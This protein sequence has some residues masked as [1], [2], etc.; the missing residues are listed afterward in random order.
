MART[1]FRPVFSAVALGGVA[2]LAVLA[3][4]PANADTTLSGPLNL[5]TATSFSVLGAS[6]VTNISTLTDPQT[7]SLDTDL[8]LSPGPTSAITGFPPGIVLG[9]VHAT[10]AVAAQ[11]QT[12]L[13]TAYNTAASLTPQTTGLTDLVGLT[14]SPGVYSGG[15]LSLSGDLTLAGSAESVWVFQASSTLITG[16]SSHIILTGGASVC[17]V[18]WQV[19]TSATLGTNSDFVG[20]I[21]AQTSIT[22]TTGADIEGRLLARTGAVTLDQ[23]TITGT[24][25]CP[26]ANGTVV[27]TSPTFVTSTPSNAVVGRAYSYRV[28]ATGGTPSTYTITSGTLPAGLRLDA[29][30]GIIS[31]T[32]TTPGTYT[33]TVTA[34]NGSPTTAVL[35]QT[36]IVA[37]RSAA[38]L[39]NTGVDTGPGAIVGTGLGLVGL[40]LFLVARSRRRSASRS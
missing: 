20:S 13:T 31:G 16:D 22:A 6:A 37:G 12:D 28:T 29:T 9:T 2:L 17:N 26:V 33:F 1:F 3:A 10:D 32:P 36:L 39:A 21:L 4:A 30:T 18:F 38:S 34:N 8:G 19:A 14:L 25:G 15:A 11:A 23:N 24:Q 35:S 7:T 27:Q 40:T 5:G